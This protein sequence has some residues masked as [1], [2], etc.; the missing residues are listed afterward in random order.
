MTQVILNGLGQRIRILFLAILAFMTVGCED[1]ITM[2]IQEANPQYVIVGEINNQNRRHEITIHRTVP[3]HAL[4]TSN[5]VEG[6]IVR[7]M[8][9][10]GRAIL[11]FDEGEGR[12]RSGNFRGQVGESYAMHVEIEGREFTA[13]STMPA[14]VPIDSAGISFGTF[15][16][17]DN[18]FI[19]FKFL[20]PP[21]T[22]N[23]Y[24]YLV[25]VN[26]GG[27]RF[28]AVFDDKFNDGKYVTHELINFDFKLQP[29]DY[30][31]VQ[32]QS[33]DRANYLYWRSVSSA[34]PTASAP[35]NPPS[36]ISNGALGYFSAH[37]MIEY[38]IYI[39]Q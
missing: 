12:Y 2:D 14:P 27:S 3:L 32:R 13:H 9:G 24:R 26:A 33:I 18:R 39:P 7:V 22:P 25:N 17:G 38:D 23:Y 29:N 28:I 36:N 8:D 37:S 19:T 10:Q 16:G 20:D 34:N 6:A 30:I 31:R 35:A 11:F 21:N 5:P 15:M 1:L 4:Q